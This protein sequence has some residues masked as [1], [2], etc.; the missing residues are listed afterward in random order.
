VRTDSDGKQYI[1]FYKVVIDEAGKIEYNSILKQLKSEFM[2][3]P[4]RVHWDPYDTSASSSSAQNSSAVKG[5]FLE[6]INLGLIVFGKQHIDRDVT[7]TGQLIVV[8][9]PGTGVFNVESQLVRITKHKM[10]ES[11]IGCDLICLT[12]P[13]LHSVPLFRYKDKM[14]DR[15]QVGCCKLSKMTYVDRNR[16]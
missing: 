10:I 9:S 11:G 3:Y 6:A 2:K 14:I 12:I 4:T 8:I 15:E 1:D 5:N 7:R 13:P 16:I